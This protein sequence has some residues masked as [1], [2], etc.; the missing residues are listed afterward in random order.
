MDNLLSLLETD[1]DIRGE[2]NRRAILRRWETQRRRRPRTPRPTFKAS[3]FHLDITHESYAIHA[4]DEFQMWDP[5]F[6]CST[7]GTLSLSDTDTERGI[8]LKSYFSRNS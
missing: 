2:N 1:R 3:D 4:F 5:R 7:D 8:V 6:A